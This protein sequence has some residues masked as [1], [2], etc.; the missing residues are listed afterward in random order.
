MN[1]AQCVFVGVLY[2]CMYIYIYTTVLNVSFCVATY[3]H[4]CIV[5]TYELVYSENYLVVTIWGL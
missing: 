1:H 3:T 4:A 5:R 2:A